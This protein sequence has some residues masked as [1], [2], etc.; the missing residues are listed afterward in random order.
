MSFIKKLARLKRSNLYPIV[1]LILIGLFFRLWKLKTFQY[2][3]D[4][5]QLLWYT[6]RHIIV[7]GHPSLVVVNTAL[8]ISLGS[9]YHLLISP[10]Y[11]LTKFNPQQILLL[12]NVFFLAS[13]FAIYKA[14]KLLGGRKTA[15]IVSFL[16]SA[17]F[18]SSLFD[19]RL[20]ALTPNF[21]VTTLSI[22]A[23]FGLTFGKKKYLYL[24]LPAFV[25][26]FNSDPSLLVAL[27]S[28][29]I[30]IILLKIKLDR[31]RIIVFTVFL[32][33]LLSPLII[34]EIRHN[35]Q[36]FKSLQN[37]ITIKNTET[38]RS[39]NSLFLVD[40]L[41]YLSRFI[42]SRPSKASEIYFCYC[43]I[44]DNKNVFPIAISTLMIAFFIFKT[45]KY[46]DK[47]DIILTVF[48]I[49]YI[50]GTFLFKTVLSRNSEFFYSIVVSPVILLIFA[51]T[52]SIKNKLI[53]AILLTFHLSIN[54]YSLI[55]SKLK[56]PLEEK[57][58]LTEAVASKINKNENFS[59]YYSGDIFLAGGGWASLFTFK[60]E[61][62]VQGS[63]IKYWG[64]AYYSYGLYPKEFSKTEPS[65]VVVLSENMTI[66]NLPTKNQRK[67]GNVYATIIDNR[68][69][70]FNPDINVEKL[71]IPKYFY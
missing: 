59:L 54:L 14:G 65:T 2:W 21:L 56:Y 71:Y 53:I 31:K 20:W 28:S 45:I 17:S 6:V 11:F 15:F 41:G 29:I 1:L 26:P 34:F 10:W 40:Q 3:S 36:N 70:L 32:L 55:N 64:H 23:L 57:I 38:K 68:K 69:K 51:K 13:L 27:I 43:N 44:E 19:R 37:L 4:D 48:L 16:Y 61:T 66:I 18:I 39:T 67:I 58:E 9:I 25:L 50:S 63:L 47:K 52:L 12:G 22:I 7:D 30:A 49:T 33:L 35:G 46:K 8:G 62:P 42:Y 5:E 24:L 60:G